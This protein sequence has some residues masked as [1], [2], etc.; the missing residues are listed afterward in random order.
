MLAVGTEL[1][2]SNVR[3]YFRSVCKAAGIG[4][5]WDVIDTPTKTAHR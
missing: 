3:R 5:D 2:A 4:E 1:D